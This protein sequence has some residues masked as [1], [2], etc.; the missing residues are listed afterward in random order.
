MSGQLATKD[1]SSIQ[2]IDSAPAKLLELAINQN[3]DV[4]KLERLMDMQIKWETSQAK[5]RYFEALSNFQSLCPPIKK[6]KAG[7]NYMYAPLS[8]IIAQIKGALKQCGM[9]FRFEQNHNDGLLVRCVVTHIDGHSES[10]EMKA[11]ADTTGSK[12]AIQA[13]GSAVTYLQRYTLIGALG[14]TTADA[15]M[16]GRLGNE[17]DWL[18]YMECIRDNYDEITNIKIAVANEQYELVKSMWGDISRESQS[19]LW[20]APSK[21]GIF[22]TNERSVIKTGS[23]S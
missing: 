8:D 4:D 14:I 18:P 9:S 13:I 17:V 21:G 19:R 16:D 2:V 6:Q 1:D 10:T 23:P 3:A 5:K 22:T 15:D 20:L 12:N 7:H 11:D